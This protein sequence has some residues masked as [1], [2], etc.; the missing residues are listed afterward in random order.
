MT[1]IKRHPRLVMTVAAAA[2]FAGLPAS[3]AMAQGPVK[4]CYV[5]VAP[6]AS[7]ATSHPSLQ[8]TVH[9]WE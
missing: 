3:S 6:P 2:L 9:C 5:E 8:A 7:A 1:F 4:H